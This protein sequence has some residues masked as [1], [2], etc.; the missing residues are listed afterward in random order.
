MDR[1]QQNEYDARESS[2]QDA[3]TNKRTLMLTGLQAPAEHV[4]SRHGESLAAHTVPLLAGLGVQAPAVQVF[5]R[6]GESLSPQTAFSFVGCAVQLPS[7][8]KPP[9]Q[10]ESRPAIGQPP[11]SCCWFVKE[12]NGCYLDGFAVEMKRVTL[13]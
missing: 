2:N 4:C 10:G 6:H 8:Q 13:L 12:A 11:P 5:S 7:T 9:R 1:A 3:Q